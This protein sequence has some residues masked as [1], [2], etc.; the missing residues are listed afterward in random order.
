MFFYVEIVEYKTG[1]V[2]RRIQCQSERNAERVERGV[3]INLNH[4][5]FY[6]RIVEDD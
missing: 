2:I 6:T 4:S 3:S 1:T 5:E